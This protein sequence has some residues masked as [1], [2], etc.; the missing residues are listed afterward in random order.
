MNIDWSLGSYEA[1]AAALEP[2]AEH[3]VELAAPQASE[4]VLDLACG[5]GNAALFAARAGAL[6]T[7]LDRARR[8]TT[9]G[10]RRAS[11]EH[12]DIA[13]VTGDVE[14]LPFGP[15]SFD[16]V[17]SVFGVI[18]AADHGQALSELLRVLRPDGRAFVS[19]WQPGGAIDATTSIFARGVAAAAP[20]FAAGPGFGWHDQHAMR[21]LA[22]AHGASVRLHDAELTFVA[23]SPEVYL[24]RNDSHPMM[25]A[26][27]PLLETA[28]TID[29]LR[30]QALEVLRSH[31]E[32]AESFQITAPYRVIEL[33]VATVGGAG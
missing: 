32:C 8:L 28:G 30:A 24:A 22:A 12:L 31:N 23:D 29:T 18:F 19:T 2:A 4:D 14:Q 3:V 21:E 13:F 33:R 5:T 1:I 27:R 15:N 26:A 11:D 9:V 10:R 6:V 17:V 16:V 20:A 25:V 7:G